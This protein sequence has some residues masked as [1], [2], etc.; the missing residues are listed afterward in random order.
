MNDPIGTWEHFN[1]SPYE[2]VIETIDPL[3]GAVLHRELVGRSNH[4]GEAARRCANAGGA[5]VSTHT[6]RAVLVTMPAAGWP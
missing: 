3:T 1:D 6:H 2:I 5:I 4:V